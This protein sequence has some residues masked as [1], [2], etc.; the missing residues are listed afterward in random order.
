[1]LLVFLTDNIKR[2]FQPYTCNAKQAVQGFMLGIQCTQE[3]ANDMGGI[4]HVIWL[5]SN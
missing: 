4:C 2:G 3:M 5:A 1:M